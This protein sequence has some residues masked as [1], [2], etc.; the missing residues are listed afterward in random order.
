VLPLLL[1]LLTAQAVPPRYTVTVLEAPPGAS[2]CFTHAINASGQ[3]VGY[4]Q[5]Q[6]FGAV[7]CAWDTAGHAQPLAG[8]RDALDVN[9][10]GLAVGWT[11]YAAPCAWV[12]PN[13]NPNL[14]LHTDG[15]AVA[16][17]AGSVLVQTSE[18]GAVLVSLSGAVTQAAEAEQPL[19]AAAL[20]SS[21]WRAGSTEFAPRRAWRWTPTQGVSLLPIPAPYLEAEAF[22]L[23]PAGTA[24]GV[25]SDS[26]SATSQACAWSPSG[27]PQLLAR[28]DP[29]ATQGWANAAG[30]GFILGSEPSGAVLWTDPQHPYAIDALL[31]GAPAGLHVWEAADANASG[32]IAASGNLGGAWLALRLDP[33]P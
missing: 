30:P 15:V 7:A 9:D 6:P 18:F 32:Q 2:N 3:V 4:A 25:A 24:L 28:L 33:V 10:A 11:D 27:V 20:N 21:G 22:G 17:N 31:N 5:L 16:C 8:G 23:S 14:V 13:A 19:H 29:N 26:S 1:A 12:L